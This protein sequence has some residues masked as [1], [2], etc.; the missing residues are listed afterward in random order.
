[1]KRFE[2]F[3]DLWQL[4]DFW[5]FVYIL[6][7]ILIFKQLQRMKTNK[8]IITF[9]ENSLK[10]VGGGVGWGKNRGGGHRIVHNSKIIICNIYYLAQCNL[11]L[12]LLSLIFYPVVIWYI[13]SFHGVVCSLPLRGQL[14]S[15]QETSFFWIAIQYKT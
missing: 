14:F 15:Y 11:W 7:T 6:L 8:Y 12:E 1:M 2:S 13:S 5:L 9:I 10:N 3:T 4:C